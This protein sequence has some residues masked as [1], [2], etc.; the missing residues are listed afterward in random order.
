MW[1]WADWHGGTFTFSRHL[2][3]CYMDLLYAQ[4]NSGRLSLEEIK[5]ILGSDFGPAWPTLQKKFIKG[6][7]GLFYNEKLEAV[8]IE[9]AEYSAKQRERVNIRWNK[10]GTYAGNTTVLPKKEDEDES[11]DEDKD[12]GRRKKKPKIEIVLPWDSD[13]FRTAWEGWKD[14]QRTQHKFSYKSPVT[15]QIALKRLSELSENT[16]AIALQ[17]IQQSMANGWKGLF[18][19]KTKSENGNRK[20]TGLS[21][22]YRRDLAKRMANAATGSQ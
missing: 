13:S 16:E 7:D 20:K 2:K 22:S 3:G 14:Y 19:I 12:V 10:S 17:I 9:R 4:F 5:T 18:E 11:V 8:M 6:P 1:Y 15:E 21:D